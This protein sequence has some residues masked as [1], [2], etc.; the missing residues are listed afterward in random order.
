MKILILSDR[1]PPNE[2]GGAGKIASQLATEYQRMGHSVHVLSTTRSIGQ[3]GKSEY[4]KVGV[5][6]IYVPSYPRLRAYYSI[7]NPTVSGEIRS[8]L[9]EFDPDVVHAHNI[10]E[11]LSYHSLGLTSAYDI[12]AFLTFHDAMSVEYGKL[13][14]FTSKPVVREHGV[15]NQCDYEISAFRQ[16]RENRFRYFPLRNILIK[17]YLRRHTASLISVSHELRSAL[18]AN[19]IENISTIHNGV[20]IGEFT[21]G[22]VSAGAFRKKYVPNSGLIIFF[23]GRLGDAKGGKKLAQAFPEVVNELETPV[24]LVVASDNLGYIDSMRSCA[25]SCANSIISTGWLGENEI[26]GAYR[27]A[28][29]V[30]TP[31]ICLDALPTMNIEAS[32]MSTPVVTTVFGGGKEVI[33]DGETG[34]V[35]NPFQTDELAKSIIEVLKSQS[36]QQKFGHQGRER[37]KKN[38]TLKNQAKQ[39]LSM[40]Q[41]EI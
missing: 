10:H 2:S 35:C 27:A 40:F 18:E 25:G 29:V 7:Y 33:S 9:E 3:T 6:R 13:T 26:K 15:V 23:G 17:R 28:S 41:S 20:R 1:F 38:F 36:V 5:N 8:C 12:P 31:S 22:G 21:K 32:A 30:V 14:N 4:G 34:L 19:G 39:Y 24:S 37:I 16:L 11:F